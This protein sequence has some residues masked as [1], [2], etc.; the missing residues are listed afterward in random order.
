[1]TDVRVA[2]QVRPGRPGGRGTGGRELAPL[3]PLAVVT[4][5]SPLAT[6]LYIPGLPE[7]AADLQTTPAVAQLTLT[8]FLVAFA[9]GQLLLGPLSD[10]VGRRRLVLVGALGFV[11]ASVLCAL[12]PNAPVLIVARLLQGLAGAAGSVA[13]RAMV[14]DVLVDVRRARVIAALSSINAVAPVVAPL[15]GGAL[16]GVGTWR[17]SFWLLAAVGL[18]LAVTVLVSFPETLPV[19]RRSAGAGLGASARRMG[20]L[21]RIPRFTLYLATSCVG[22]VGFFAYIATSSFVFQTW[23]GYSSSRYTLVFATNAS[24]M[25]ISTL[26][27]GRVVGRVSEDRLL[28]VGLLVATAGSAGVLTAALLHAPGGLVWA[29]LAVV[30]GAQGLVITGSATRTQALGQSSPGT[31]AALQ[32]GLAFGVGGLG[33]PL[34]GLLGGTPTAMGGVMLAGLGAGLLL[35]TVGARWLARRTV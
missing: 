32:G 21:L 28:T 35:Q 14:T 3:V 1:M 7:L 16:L 34:A 15:V 19:E 8:A 17:L 23:Y 33:T 29:F 9:A 10:A 31:A 27:F 5:I 2:E 4:G 22:T 25:I 6:D 26:I 12:A 11:V 20:S 24:C 18:V 30:T 13:G